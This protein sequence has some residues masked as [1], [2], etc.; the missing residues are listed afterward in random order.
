M[1]KLNSSLTTERQLLF[2]TLLFL[3][4]IILYETGVW[5]PG[6]S[7]MLYANNE[8]EH[9]ILIKGNEA[10][11]ITSGTKMILINIED[12]TKKN[13]VRFKSIDSTFI[14]VTPP[15]QKEQN[16]QVPINNV[17]EIRV[18]KGTKA[19]KYAGRGFLIGGAAGIAIIYANK[20]SRETLGPAG[21]LCGLP[22][23]LLG[24]GIG[25]IIGSSVKNNISYPIG[26]GQWHIEV[27]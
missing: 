11:Y 4:A 9:L 15:K 20:E 7:D 3:I 5:Q 25:G 22:T 16:N 27:K 14:N 8:K 2:L 23:G 18:P 10:I 1:K 13:I 26:P 12:T 17:K 21:L 24:A 6:S 19:G